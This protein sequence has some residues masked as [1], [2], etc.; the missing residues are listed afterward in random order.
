MYIDELLS[1]VGGVFRVGPVGVHVLDGPEDSVG[2]VRVVVAVD[3][4]PHFH[5]EELLRYFEI[6][7]QAFVLICNFSVR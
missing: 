6:G 7:Q 2:V 5:V 1:D 3:V 4:L